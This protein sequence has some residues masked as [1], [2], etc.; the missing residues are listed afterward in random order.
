MSTPS[1]AV[2]VTDADGTQWLLANGKYGDA[3]TLGVLHTEAEAT[4]LVRRLNAKAAEV[5]LDHASAIE[6]FIPGPELDPALEDQ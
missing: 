5:G 2:L 1:H 3:Q 4:S 6:A